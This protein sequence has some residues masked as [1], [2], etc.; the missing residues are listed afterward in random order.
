MPALYLWVFFDSTLALALG[1]L[2]AV[3]AARKYWYWLTI[4][5]MLIFLVGGLSSVERLVNIFQN[6][7]VGV[8][9]ESLIAADLSAAYRVVPVFLYF[10]AVDISTAAFWLGHGPDYASTFIELPAMEE[11][12]FMGGLIPSLLLDYGFLAF[13]IFIIFAHRSAAGM[14]LFV[15]YL[16]FIV[17][18][19]N[20]SLNT[21]LMWC[22]IS[23]FAIAK[24]IP[25]SRFNQSGRGECVS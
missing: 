13:I 3:I 2:I 17:M 4:A 24:M 1:V 15:F 16:M 25:C 23:F 11:N 20:A 9:D 8:I 14:N 22:F 5:G 10:D 7:E 6:L 12:G 19:T 18:M 21:Q